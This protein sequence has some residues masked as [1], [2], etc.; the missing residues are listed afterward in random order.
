MGEITA[1]QTF[2]PAWRYFIEQ[3]SLGKSPG[4]AAAEAGFKDPRAAATELLGLPAVRLALETSGEARLMG[5][6]VPLALDCIDEILRDKTA[7]KAVKAKLALGIV[8][9]VIRKRDAAAP[10]VPGDGK[11]LQDMSVTE[12]QNLVVQL[13]G[14][15][16]VVGEMRDVTPKE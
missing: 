14:Q 11:A 12:L 2:P 1:P 16:V 10:T 4:E 8:D 3:V 9:R 15:G 6:S 13:G 7:P 5:V